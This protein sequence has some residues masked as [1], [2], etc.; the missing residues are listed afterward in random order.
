MSYNLWT[1]G[2][3][4]HWSI[5]S[6]CSGTDKLLIL[7]V[8]YQQH[9]IDTPSAVPKCTPTVQ[10]HHVAFSLDDHMILLCASRPTLSVCINMGIAPQVRHAFYSHLGF[11]RVGSRPPINL[12]WAK[13]ALTEL[14]TYSRTC[15]G[16][17]FWWPNISS[18]RL[19]PSRSVPCS[20]PMKALAALCGR[21][22]SASPLRQW[23]RT[24]A[25]SARGGGEHPMQRRSRT[26]RQ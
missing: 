25:R 22:H 12:D 21:Q 3:Q 4:N 2:Q 16:R 5:F 11:G 14:K 8:S 20:H 19:G 10:H 17:H 24:A 18:S 26:G 15:T 6:S 13:V 9:L 1:A 7:L 23:A